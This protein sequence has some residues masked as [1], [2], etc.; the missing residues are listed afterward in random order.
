MKPAAALTWGL[1]TPPRGFTVFLPRCGDLGRIKVSLQRQINIRGRPS[2]PPASPTGGSVAGDG[3]LVEDGGPLEYGGPRRMGAH[4]PRWRPPQAAAGAQR[5]VLGLDHPFGMQFNRVPS[6][7]GWRWGCGPHV[8]PGGTTPFIPAS[9]PGACA[10]VSDLEKRFSVCVGVCCRMSVRV[11]GRWSARKLRG[12]RVPSVQS[13]GS[14]GGRS[15]EPG[16]AWERAES[17]SPAR[18]QSRGREVQVWGGKSKCGPGTVAWGDACYTPQAAASPPRGAGWWPQK[19]CLRRTVTRPLFG[20]GSLQVHLRVSRWHYLR[21][22]GWALH[23]VT[24]VLERD[25]RGEDTDT[26]RGHVKTEA[27]PGVMRPQA[28]D[29][30][31][32]QELEEARSP[33]PTRAS[34][35]A[36][37]CHLDFRLLASR[38]SREYIF[39]L[40]SPQFVAVCHSSPGHS[41]S[42]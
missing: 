40:I 19:T 11:R 34:G 8:C 22:S 2:P 41:Q 16:C 37:P 39:V 20:E 38:T 12:G 14:A 25:R 31:S 28:K 21:L 32:H 27:K 4:P 29:P 30:R 24:N 26:W 18:L 33:A 17:G 6:G 35:R 9:P 1:L 3:G 36:S 42:P 5:G 7:P 13:Q 10:C 23:P 15:W